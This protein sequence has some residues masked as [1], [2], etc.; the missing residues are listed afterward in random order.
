MSSRCFWQRETP[1]LSDKVTG[2]SQ[3]KNYY[4]SVK[5]WDDTY[6]IGDSAYFH[7]ES[8]TLPYK[9]P[10]TK[11]EKVAGRSKEVSGHVTLILLLLAVVY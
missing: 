9:P 7:P 5:Y 6:K 1:Q 10:I 11:K 8:F 4:S 3:S 2:D